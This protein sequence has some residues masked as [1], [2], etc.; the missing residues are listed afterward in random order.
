MTITHSNEKMQIWYKT[1]V[2]VDLLKPYI[3][4]L[5]KKVFLDNVEHTNTML[6]LKD[7]ENENT[8]IIILTAHF[9]AK[10]FVS[11]IYYKNALND[12]GE[13]FNI[14]QFDWKLVEQVSYLHTTKF[15]CRWDS[16]TTQ[17]L[18]NPSHP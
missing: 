2:D 1:N 15:V 3:V 7:E 5:E 8:A 16:L 18:S 17:L 4:K 12:V 6:V 14:P 9:S 13:K 10:D 11:K